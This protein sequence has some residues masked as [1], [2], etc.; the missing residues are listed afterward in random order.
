[1]LADGNVSVGAIALVVAFI[2]LC[3][4]FVNLYLGRR[5]K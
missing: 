1:M 3:A 2:A 5:N 4:T